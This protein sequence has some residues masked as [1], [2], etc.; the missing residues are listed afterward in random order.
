M[1]QLLCYCLNDQIKKVWGDYFFDDDFDWWYYELDT[2]DSNYKYMVIVEL[3]INP[4]A[5]LLDKDL[6][7]DSTTIIGDG[8]LSKDNQ[9]VLFL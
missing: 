4:V 7:V 3:P 9:S 8:V 5:Y 1:G 6:Q 2:N